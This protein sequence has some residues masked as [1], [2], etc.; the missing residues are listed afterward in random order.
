MLCA[1]RHRHEYTAGPLLTQQV[2]VSWKHHMQIKLPCQ[3]LHCKTLRGNMS[4]K[5]I[6][7]LIFVQ[8]ILSLHQ[9]PSTLCLQ[10]WGSRCESE[11]DKG[12][13]NFNGLRYTVV[14]DTPSEL[15]RGAPQASSETKGQIGP[16]GTMK[17]CHYS[18]YALLWAGKVPLSP[19]V[20][21]SFLVI[22]SLE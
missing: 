11:R 2:C 20:V 12:H 9:Q 18:S 10:T 16:F 7:P 15:L 22:V 5:G 13:I 1:I 14:W 19:A 6:L 3:E 8:R 21:L 17:R 4:L